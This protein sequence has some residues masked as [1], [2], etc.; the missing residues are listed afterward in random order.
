MYGFAVFYA[1]C[2]V[3][4][5]WFY[6]R[7]TRTSRTPDSRPTDGF[8]FSTRVLPIALDERSDDLRGANHESFSR[9]PEVFDK[10]K[11]TFSNGHG[12]V[13]NE[14]RN[15]EDAYRNRWRHDK[16]VR[17]THGELHR[18]LFLEDLRQERPGVVRDAADRLPA[19]L[20]G[21]AQPRAARLPAGA[22]FSWYLYSPHRIKY[23][24]I[25]GRLLD[26]YRAEK[27]GQR[28]RSR[29]GRPSR[30]IPPSAIVRAGA[31]L[32]GFVRTS[33]DE[34]HRD[35]RRRQRPHHRQRGPDRIYGFLADSPPCP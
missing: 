24:M 13:T 22:S 23:P 4:N 25:R 2:V 28:T 21:P 27:K 11:E 1:L 15:W 10:V 29:P 7:K 8:P 9:P 14:D 6:L 5:W 16:V 17:S 26:L 20:R 30:P 33:W 12:I 35:R 19:H 18:R 34:G 32:G 31:G 3:L